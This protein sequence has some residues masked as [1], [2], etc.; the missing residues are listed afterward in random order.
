MKRLFTLLGLSVLMAFAPSPQCALACALQAIPSGHYEVGASALA[1]EPLAGETAVGLETARRSALEGAS[2]SAWEAVGVP[3]A[4]A[5]ASETGCGSEV[6]ADLADMPALSYAEG[7]TGVRPEPQGQALGLSSVERLLPRPQ[8]LRQ[9]QG[10]LAPRGFRL[11]A[12]TLSAEYAEWLRAMGYAEGRGYKAVLRVRLVEELP[13]VERNVDEAY[14]LRVHSE[15]IEVVA[16][17]SRGA[18]YA[19]QTLRQLG[20][21]RRPLPLVEIVDWPSWYIRGVMH[22]VGRTF[23][24]LEELKRQIATM[25]QF[26]LNTFHWHLTE[27]QAWRLES[28]AYPQLT[29]IAATE[30]MPGQYYT[31]DQ[32]RELAQWCRAHQVLLIPEI[33]MPGHSAAFERAMGYG[34]QTEMGKQ[35]LK[36][37]LRE[38]AEAIDMPYIHIGTDEVEFTDPTFVPEM[39]AYVRSLGRRAVSWHPGWQYATDEIDM[40]QLW[41]AHGRPLAGVPAIDSRL[42]YTNHYDLFAD[43]RALYLSCIHNTD[44]STP[45]LAGSIIALWNDRYLEGHR[46][47]MSENG[48]YATMLALAERSWLGGGYGYFD[49]PTLV[50]RDRQADAFRDFADFERRLLHYKAT[51]LAREPIPYVKQTHAVWQVIDA[52]PNGGDL[53]KSF[54]PERTLGALARGATPRPPTKL[55]S[56]EYEGHTYGATEVYGSGQYLRHVWGNALCPAV[57]ADPQPNHTA[58]AVAWVY[59]PRRMTAGLLL[60]TQSYSRSERDLPPP[61]GAWDHRQSR[62]WLNGKP[63]SPPRWTS[64]HTE[65]SYEI[66]L[67]NENA[68]S[69]PPIPVELR[70]GWNELLLKLPVGAFSTPETRLVKWMYTASFVTPDGRDALDLRYSSVRP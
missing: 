29:S 17:T 51:T 63:I 67:G 25:A 15:G 4:D 26:K 19:L 48:L 23:I 33:D 18:Y 54:P 60:E 2:P 65:R 36:V 45:E 40:T 62:V 69:R 1:L 49:A 55:L 5:S 12:E 56:Y 27:N 38:V 22:D 3:S 20:E 13:E 8:R 52:F 46:Q 21:P 39:V 31:L 66:P 58:Y 70:A 32:A 43:V 42:H 64:T 34:M 50:F 44:H 24:P 28:R 57:Y 7:A 59:A 14:T 47:I 35:A 68:V 11:E 53:S 61:Q 9:G 10:E 16:R 30:R 37:I 6:W 41:S